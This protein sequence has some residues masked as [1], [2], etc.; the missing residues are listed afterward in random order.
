[1]TSYSQAQHDLHMDAFS[2]GVGTSPAREA[3]CDV[4]I[5]G[6]GIA[7]AAAAYETATNASVVILEREAQPG[8]HS[9]GRSAALFSETYGNAV[10]RALTVGS[11]SFL[12]GPPDGFTEHPL[13]TVRGVLLV[14]RSDQLA[15]AQAW[16]D[17]AAALVPSVHMIDAQEVRK[18]VPI[19]RDGYLAGAVAEPEAMDIDVHA[20]HSGFLRGARDRGTQVVTDAEV[21][22][23]TRESDGNWLVRSSAGLWRARS[24]V[25]AAGAWADRIAE[26]AGVPTV[27]LVPKR[28][29]ASMV[30]APAGTVIDA[31]P[32]VIDIDEKF[33][34]KPD[35]GRILVSPAD[36]T[37]VDPCDAQPDE[38][39]IAIGIDR[40][41]TAA[42]LPVKRVQHSWA[43]LRNFVSDKTP[44]VGFDPSAPG[45]FWLAG[46]G[47]YGIQTAPAMGRLA[48]SLL[49]NRGVPDDLRTLGVTLEALSPDRLRT[50]PTF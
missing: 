45:F 21:L 46:Q 6:A 5:V 37:P 18:Q 31:W 44:V 47:G 25:N 38:L 13:L 4:L 7:G 49:L 11:R 26:F 9:T 19:L 10:V 50:P 23:L 33:Y 16:A 15:Q 32:V 41:Q 28:R 24:V 39:D 8:Y 3:E 36:E 27:G 1:M 29:T 42:E 14:A 35:A 30:E 12:L 22:E 48:G 17:E 43:G 40:V 20:L 34:F 2:N